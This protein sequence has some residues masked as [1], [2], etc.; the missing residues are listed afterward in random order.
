MRTW[1][2]LP[3][4]PLSNH[5][6]AVRAECYVAKTLVGKQQ[7][8]SPVSVAKCWFYRIKHTCRHIKCAEG[9]AHVLKCTCTCTKIWVSSP[10]KYYWHLRFKSLTWHS[11]IKDLV[12]PENCTN[13]FIVS[14]LFSAKWDRG[15][16]MCIKEILDN[17]VRQFY[18]HMQ[19]VWKQDK[20][21][22]NVMSNLLQHGFSMGRPY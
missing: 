7:M 6:H 11:G 16:V 1:H 22:T 3:A 17:T 9:Y 13:A 18:N 4:L 21:W 12:S 10:Q 15:C 5:R 19:H 14:H 8:H 20:C 2:L